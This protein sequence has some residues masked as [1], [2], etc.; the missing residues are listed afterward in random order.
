M[1]KAI[2]A[3]LDGIPELGEMCST[4]FRSPRITALTAANAGWMLRFIGGATLVAID[5]DDRSG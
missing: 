4:F 1:R 3:Q 2:S 5:G